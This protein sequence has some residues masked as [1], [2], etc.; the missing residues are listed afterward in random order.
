MA[1]DHLEVPGAT[2]NCGRAKNCVRADEKESL[3]QHLE[4]ELT[5]TLAWEEGG[6]RAAC[7]LLGL[8]STPLRAPNMGWALPPPHSP[9]PLPELRAQI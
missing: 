5:F 7:P 6:G 2:F 4:R 1:A 8:L 3:V 9:Q